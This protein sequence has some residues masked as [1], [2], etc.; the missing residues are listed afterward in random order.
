MPWYE[1]RYGVVRA[2][3]RRWYRPSGWSGWKKKS[4]YCP[5]ELRILPANEAA[6]RLGL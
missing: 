5:P 3:V 1:K 6:E 4:K 2:V